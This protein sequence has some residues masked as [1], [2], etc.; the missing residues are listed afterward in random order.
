V[1]S[2][3]TDL[4]SKCDYTAITIS[5]VPHSVDRELVLCLISAVVDIQLVHSPIAGPSGRRSKAQVLPLGYWDRG[6]ESLSRH[7]CL[8]LCFCAVLSC[9]G[10]GLCDGLIT[11]PKES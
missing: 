8:S 5:R 3:I 10:R 2:W 6:F 9:V 7:G 11:R 1:L 4:V